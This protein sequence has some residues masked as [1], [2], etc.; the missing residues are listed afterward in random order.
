LPAIV[1]GHTVD[2]VRY[3]DHNATTPLTPAAREAWQRAVEEHWYNPSSPYR[4]AARVRVRLD[5]TRSRLAELL[6]TD[7]KRLV[8]T[9]G[10]TEAA[11]GIFAYLAETLPAH[12]RI[13]VN[14]TEHPCVLEAARIH[15][16]VQRID[17]LPVTREG[18]VTA[19]T[20]KTVLQRYSGS[21]DNATGRLGAVVVMAA[22]NETGVLQPWLELARLCRE[23]GATY[24]CD[25]SQWL[26]KLPAGGLAEA[27]W[28]FGAAHKFGAPKGVGFL[29][30]AAGADGFS[31]RRGG[32]QENGQRAGTEDFAGIAAMV[33]ALAD[34][35]QAK[36]LHETER[37]VWRRDFEREVLSRLPGVQIVGANS[38]RLWNTVTMVMPHGEN[39]RWAARL[40][41]HGFAVATG[42]ACATGRAKA[43]HVLAAMG[44]ADEEAKR[45]IRASAGWGTTPEDWTA[46]GAALVT[47]ATEVKPSNDVVS[48]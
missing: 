31:I 20:A 2:P 1:A 24:V 37:L 6:D 32:G 13:A 15:F 21:G 42:S 38:E 18:V 11:A 12:A 7:P 41:H 35:E 43:S 36:V 19:E 33:A 44:Y 10:A 30:R 14:P 34:A 26:G 25:A 4:A 28:V 48:V 47:V 8:F 9:G 27:D 22:N 46:L 17:W 23:A 45:V 3:F 16:G 39:A 40:D 5:A 29:Q